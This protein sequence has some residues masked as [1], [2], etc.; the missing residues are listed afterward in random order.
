[1][2]EQI[3]RTMD[4]LAHNRMNSHYVD[5]KAEVL[6]LVRSLLPEGCSVGVGGSM[7]LQVTGVMEL[8]RSGAYR[9]Y[10]RYAPDLTPEQRNEVFREAAFADVF[11]CSSNAVTEQGELYN[12]DGHSNRIAALAFGP[13]RVVVIAGIN[14]LVP[15]LPAAVRRVKE[16]AA[17]LNA[18]RLHCDTYCNQ[19]GHCLHPQG[20]MNEGCA[21]P[22]RICRNALVS[23]MQEDPQ[24]LHVILVGEALG[25]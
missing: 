20:G 3:K 22:Q 13:G 15:D 2:T 12:V 25:Y 21:S 16:V 17:P 8:L 14:K 1:M 11:L 18:R 9:F 24:R 6:P 7:T 10:D 5:T 23:A 19:A 4:A